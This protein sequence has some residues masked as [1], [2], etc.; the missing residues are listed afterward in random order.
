M[1]DGER[2]E[3]VVR[4]CHRECRA[5]RYRCDPAAGI[6]QSRKGAKTEKIEIANP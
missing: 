1:P 3:V 2:P 4:D 6:S 5:E